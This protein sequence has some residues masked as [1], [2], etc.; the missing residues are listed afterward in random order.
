MNKIVDSAA[1]CGAVFLQQKSPDVGLD[2]GGD[3]V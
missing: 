3:T 1:L 2:A